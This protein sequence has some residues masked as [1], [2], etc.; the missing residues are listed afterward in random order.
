MGLNAG[1][2]I[3]IPDSGNGLKGIRKSDCSPILLICSPI[4]KSTEIMKK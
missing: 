3:M 2:I 4:N 1:K